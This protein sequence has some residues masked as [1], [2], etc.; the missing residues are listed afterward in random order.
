M[1]QKKKQ[2]KERKT[3]KLNNMKKGQLINFNKGI[4][5]V[6]FI[7]ECEIQVQRTT[8]PK[9]TVCGLHRPKEKQI[10]LF[11]WKNYVSYELA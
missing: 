6:V 9:I 3:L 10:K 4:F 2:N 11:G 7:D 5:K 1:A 8:E